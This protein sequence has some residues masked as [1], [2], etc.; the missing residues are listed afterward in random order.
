MARPRRTAPPLSD[1]V[2]EI[3]RLGRRCAARRVELRMTQQALA[4]L[5]GV[6]RSSVQAFEYGNGSVGLGAVVE[7]VAV[8]GWRVDLIASID[9]DGQ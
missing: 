4:D 9:P 6:S 2:P 5:A 1:A 8:L 3:S 7:V